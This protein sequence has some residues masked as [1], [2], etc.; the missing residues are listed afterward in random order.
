[1]EN[2][3]LHLK[4]KIIINELFHGR[5]K[6]NLIIFNNNAQ[7]RSEIQRFSQKLSAFFFSCIFKTLKLFCFFETN[8]KTQEK[9]WFTSV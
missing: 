1:M 6:F 4:L 7:K 5:G 8:K 2:N 9:S 3:Y